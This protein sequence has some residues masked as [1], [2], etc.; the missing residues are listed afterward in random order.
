MLGIEHQHGE[1]GELEPGADPNRRLLS[2]YKK[3]T[4]PPIALLP[5]PPRIRPA[6]SRR[7]LCLLFLLTIATNGHDRNPVRRN[8][9]SRAH[10]AEHTLSRC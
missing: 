10:S 2:A 8:T 5:S 1:H 6:R 3:G 9:T 7:R 4:S